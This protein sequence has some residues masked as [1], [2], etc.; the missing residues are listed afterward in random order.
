MHNN[1]DLLILKSGRVVAQLCCVLAA[2]LVVLL[3]SSTESAPSV[4]QTR[5]AEA[6]AKRPMLGGQV[7]V[8]VPDGIGVSV[9]VM[10]TR[11][12]RVQIAALHNALGFGAR[13]GVVFLPAPSF[14]VH[15]RPLISVEGGAH[16]GGDASWLTGVDPMVTA[17]LGKLNYAFGNA[18]VGFE[19]GSSTFAFVFRAGLS[20]VN[21]S[22]AS[23]DIP[24][25]DTTVTMQGLSLRGFIPS[26]RLGVM[27]A[28]Q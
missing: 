6:P 10:P 22:I 1:T 25:S 4:E 27:F 28:F 17:A 13:A 24:V 11:W 20:Y 8:G 5:E 23:L 16:F 12:M 7:D 19:A 3:V 9:M 14:F 2:A 15:F 26:V 21:A 18:Q